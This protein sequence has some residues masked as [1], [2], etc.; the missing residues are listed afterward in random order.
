MIKVL[1]SGVNGKMGQTLK[2]SIAQMETMVVVAGVDKNPDACQNPFPVYE[3]FSD[4][5]ELVDAIIDF[6]RPETLRGALEYAT[7]KHTSIL[8]ATT[9]YSEKDKDLIREASKK[10]P[11]FF[12][13][14]MS[15]GVNLQMTLAKHA[16]EFLGDK[17]DIEIIEKHHNQKVDAPSGTA[18]AIARHINSAYMYT[19]K[20]VYGRNP[21]SGKREQGEIGIHAVRGG[22]VVGDHEVLF[23]GN[24]ENIIIQHTA[25]SK[26]VFAEGAIRAIEF[27]QDKQAGL[28]NMQD[29][30]EESNI[31]STVYYHDDESIITMF[32]VPHS[33]NTVAKIF[34]E[35]GKQDVNVD[36]ISQSFP[37]H[38]NDTIDISFS[39]LGSDVVKASNVINNL[40]GIEFQCLS[41]ISKLTIEGIGMAKESG[42]AARMFAALEKKNV[43]VLLL[44]TSET[45][46]ACC[47]SSTDV[48]KALESVTAE[49]GL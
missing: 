4:V 29:M 42:V 26:E 48:K 8:L 49:F 36:I 12:S 27:L 21:H 14:N 20:Y 17:Y 6:S 37:K 3:R 40:G 45:K 16:A 28:Y 31:V 18:L 46:I 25:L 1:L 15:L 30:I 39:L 43:K 23:L 11:V 13:A 19:K 22:T 7:S 44:T 47:I 24:G 41:N 10:I 32:D 9:G 2:N 33:P 34:T 38:E 5:V 35:L